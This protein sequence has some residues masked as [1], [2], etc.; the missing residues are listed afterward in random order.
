M[1]IFFKFENL[2]KDH[3]PLV[4][5]EESVSPMTKHKNIFEFFN[6]RHL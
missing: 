1:S 4:E 6:F 5:E 3:N 2:E